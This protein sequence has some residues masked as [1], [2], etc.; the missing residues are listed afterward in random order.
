MNTSI[1]QECL[2]YIDFLRSIGYF[3]SLSG[4]DSKF[5]PYISELS[6][7]E[8]HLHSVCFYLKQN[9]KTQGKCV[10]NKQK[11]NHAKITEP[12]YSCCY[13]GVE[14]FVIPVLY[15]DTCIMCINISGYR[16]TLKK[17]KKFM[18]RVLPECDNHFSELYNELSISVPRFDDVMK[19]ISPLKYMI[20]ELYKSCESMSN[21][22]NEIPLAKQIYFRAI[23]FIN[24]NYMMQLS[25]DYVAKQLNYSASYLHYIFK[26]EG[27]TT[28]KAC[29]NDV[30]LNKAKHLLSHTQISITD[31]ALA[32]GFLDS[33][34]FSTAFKNKYGIPP[35]KYR[36]IH[37]L[38]KQS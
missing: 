3:V 29:I 32:C 34:Y 9:S 7:Y 18:E 38:S 25:C 4:F 22:L 17:S 37:F 24:E 31:V 19:F 16:G 27:N 35:K 5:E 30:R 33:N 6:D 12:Y 21:D 2:N 8:I 11:L 14:E 15:Q 13:A 28:I 36:D 20:I 1:L 23:N 10:L 26:K